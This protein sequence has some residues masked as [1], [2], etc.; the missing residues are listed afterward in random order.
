MNERSDSMRLP[1][2]TAELALNLG[3]AHYRSPSAAVRTLHARNVVPQGLGGI[4]FQC[5]FDTTPCWKCCGG[6]SSGGYTSCQAVCCPAGKRCVTSCELATG[7]AHA[8]CV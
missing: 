6:G 5:P 4:F 7:N 8:V 1:G 2:Y 3:G